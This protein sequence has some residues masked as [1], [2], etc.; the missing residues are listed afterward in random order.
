MRF[1]KQER[2][3]GADHGRK[4]KKHHEAKVGQQLNALEKH[5]H[6]EKTPTEEVDTVLR[7]VQRRDEGDLN[8]KE[9]AKY[10]SWLEVS[11]NSQEIDIYKENLSEF[12]KLTASVKAGGG[13]RQTSRNA[14]ARTHLVTGIRATAEK[15]RQAYP[16]E[17]IVMN[18][19]KERV[20]RHLN[21]WKRIL[22]GTNDTRNLEEIVLDRLAKLA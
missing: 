11:L 3:F 7:F 19:L 14:R 20:E 21:N 12:E 13:G 1:R 15:S 4:K 16:N 17:E 5:D 18:K 10:V 8:M 6:G 2:D 22:S 9:F